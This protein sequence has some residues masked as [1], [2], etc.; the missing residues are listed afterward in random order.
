MKAESVRTVR[1][2]V[3]LPQVKAAIAKH[4]NLQAQV[5][6][7]TWQMEELRATV[8]RW[9]QQDVADYDVMEQLGIVHDFWSPEEEFACKKGKEKRRELKRG[10]RDHNDG[11]IKRARAQVRSM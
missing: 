7:L 2:C 3:Y 9:E 11:V 10:R 6:T 4:G 8:S 1:V 5:Q